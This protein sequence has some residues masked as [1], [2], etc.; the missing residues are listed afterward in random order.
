MKLKMLTGLSG[1]KYSLSPGDSHDFPEEEAARLILAGF[2]EEDAEAAEAQAKA[3]ADA[4]LQ[5]EADA[6]AKA[7]AA[8]AKKPAT[9]GKAKN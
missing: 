7:A 2:A 9:R 3:E 4:N 6:V 8:A 1:P 5:A